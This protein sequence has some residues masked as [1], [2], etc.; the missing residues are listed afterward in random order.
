MPVFSLPSKYG[1]GDFGTEAYK[2]IDFLSESKQKFWEILPLVQTGYGNSPYSS[3]CSTSYSVYYIS[4]EA[5]Y[6]D[7]LI[8]KS[9]LKKTVYKGKYIDYGFLYENR[10]PLLRKA[11]SRFDKEDK[12]FLAFIKKKKAY[13]FALFTAIKL[14]EEQKPFY[15]WREELKLRDKKVLKTFCKNNSEEVLFW[16]FTQYLAEKQWLSLKKYANKKGVKIIGDMPLYVSSDSVDV[17]KNPKLFKLNAHLTPKKIA[18]VPPDYFSKDGQLWGNPVY[19]YDFHRQDNFSWWKNRVKGALKIF[20][21]VRIDH[22]RGLDRFYEIEAN[23]QTAKE[24]VW[25]EVPSDELFSAIHSA[26][27]KR[28]I[29]AEDLGVIDDGVKKLLKAT[30]YPSM[31]ILSFAFNGDERNPYLPENVEENSVCFT[32]THDNDTLIGFIESLKEEERLF[33]AKRVKKSLIGQGVKGRDDGSVNLAKSVIELGFSVK[34]K[35][36][37]LSATD[38]LL[39]G[40]DYR[41]NEPGTVKEQNWAVRFDGRDF[42]KK[43][44]NYLV[45]LSK[46]HK[47]N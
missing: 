19:D 21:L 26:V 32:G 23:A 35:L 44:V 5:L 8:K 33:F 6:K 10:L 29:I 20:D 25:V 22:F 30:G 15:E 17:W 27:D 39:K 24:G 37:I 13:D 38:L 4:P 45:K 34:S 11:F 9:E 31:K 40:T 47:R 3:V 12:E 14:F 43:Q 28:K 2:F 1:I 42:T 41:I 36:F 16:Q 7:G 46:K 18:G